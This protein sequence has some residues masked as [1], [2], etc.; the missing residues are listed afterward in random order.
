L[1]FPR[2]VATRSAEIA[3][4]IALAVKTHDVPTSAAPDPPNR[5]PTSVPA[6]PQV[7]T[8]EFAWGSCLLGT[9]RGTAAAAA[10]R[11]GAATIA[12][13]ALHAEQRQRRRAER[14]RDEADGPEQIGVDHHRSAVVAIAERTGDRTDQAREGE[15]DRR[16]RGHP[17]R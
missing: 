8:V 5:G 13:T 2:S 7:V 16:D 9:M 17:D 14:E 1:K 12:A 6:V 11:K 4:L 15:R 3:K 10:G